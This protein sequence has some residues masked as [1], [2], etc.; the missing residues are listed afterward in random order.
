MQLNML[1]NCYIIWVSIRLFQ[2]EIQKSHQ[3]DSTF[4][5][6]DLSCDLLMDDAVVLIQDF[7]GWE[8]S[9]IPRS[10]DIPA[11]NF[12]KHAIF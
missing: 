3:N 5:S 4:G 2:K 9:W 11:S 8:V 12:A 6:D 10:F 7:M 1:F